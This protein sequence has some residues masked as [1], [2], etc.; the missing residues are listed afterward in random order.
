MTFRDTAQLNAVCRALLERAGAPLLWTA[1]G[2][3]HA[4]TTAL[5]TRPARLSTAADALLFLAFDFLAEFQHQEITAS[6]VGVV[7]LRSLLKPQDLRAVGLLLVALTQGPTAVDEWL[8]LNR[9]NRLLEAAV[10]HDRRASS[11]E[12][13]SQSADVRSEVSH[14]RDL[15]AQARATAAAL[16]DAQPASDGTTLEVVSRAAGGVDLFLTGKPV[17]DSSVLE[18]RQG[19]T[20]RRGTL[21]LLGFDGS[22]GRFRLQEADAPLSA[23]VD[24]LS[25][26]ETSQSLLLSK[27]RFRWPEAP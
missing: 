14:H 7:E 10:H 9:R 23:A 21:H 20:W 27:V 15:A 26:E 12:Q 8:A 5:L 25:R 1:T 17:T 22:R 13:L 6:V 19:G 4:A 11:L 18:I 16:Q 3:A 24:A 2:P